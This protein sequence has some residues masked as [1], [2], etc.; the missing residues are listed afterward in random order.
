[1][2]T[3]LPVA[4]IALAIIILVW[5]IVLAGRISQLRQAPRAFQAI[6]GMAAL[7]ILPALLL[8]LATTTIITGRAVATMDWVWPAVLVL[9]TVQAV[10]AVSHR[11]VNYLWGVPIAVYDLVIAIAGIMR[12]LIAHGHAPP[13]PFV[14]LLA[15]QS[16]A[17]VFITGTASVLASPIYLNVP[18]V[19]PAFP[20]LRKLTASFRGFMTLVAVFWVVVIVA[21]GAPRAVEAMRGYTAHE[22]DRLRERPDGDFAVG[23]KILPDIGSYPSGT[24]VRTDYATADTLDVDAI[25]V[26]LMPDVSRAVV[27]S[28]ARVLDRTRRDSTTLIVTVGYRGLLVPELRRASLDE[29]QR[30]ATVRSIVS[31]IHPDIILP[32]QDPYGAGQRALGPIS[33]ERWE[34]FLARA[35]RAAKSADPHV[36]VGVSAAAFSQRDSVLYAWAAA[37]G[38]PIDVVGFSFFPSPYYGG[39]LASLQRAADR[40][41]RAMPPKKE[42]WVFAAGGYPLSYGELSQQRVIW[43]S[44]AWATD[45]PAIKGL[46][47]FEAGDYGQS[48]GLRAPNGRLRMAAVAVMKAISGL[49]E[50]AR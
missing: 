11:L 20:A 34:R 44:L 42:H 15:A 29:Q 50:S 30:L 28:V 38:S 27:D 40:W 3:W 46:V 13:E 14:V 18:M 39:E 37:P 35:A 49:R 5:D 8:A 21:V 48:R 43:Q 7:L 9:F 10:Y 4:H 23:L 36:K 24:A 45:H 31:R 19:S 17:M 2:R 25:T 41:M 12:Y 32:A 1:M 33:P 47:V 26:V 6:S 16:T 22:N